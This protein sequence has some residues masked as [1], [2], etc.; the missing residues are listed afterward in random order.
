MRT[1]LREQGGAL[2]DVEILSLDD[3]GYTDDVEEGICSC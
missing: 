2:E 3:I 1:L